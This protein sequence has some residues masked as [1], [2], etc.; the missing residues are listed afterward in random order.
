MATANESRNSAMTSEAY[1]L[2]D[3]FV[4]GLDDVVY[5]VAEA[6]AAEKGQITSDDTVEITQEDVR[7]AAEVV[8]NAIHAAAGKSIPAAV[9][10]QIEEMHGC[11]M[12]KCKVLDAGG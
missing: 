12:E 4:S 3:C 10:E 7:A 2:L 6:M 9:V 8:F 1:D 11:V 5:K